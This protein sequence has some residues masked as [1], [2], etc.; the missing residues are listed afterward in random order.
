ML[1]LFRD[2]FCWHL[3]AELEALA[4]LSLQAVALPQ[5]PYTS[6]VSS[7]QGYQLWL[8]WSEAGVWKLPSHQVGYSRAVFYHYKLIP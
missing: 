1:D 3:Q 2:T 7:E 8:F 4:S 5:S 6:P